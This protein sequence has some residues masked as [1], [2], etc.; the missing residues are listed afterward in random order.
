MS[1]SRSSPGDPSSTRPPPPARRCSGAGTGARG[2][3][4]VPLAVLATPSGCRG[5]SRRRSRRS[6]RGRR[7]GSGPASP[8]RSRP[9]SP[10]RSC[11]G[12]RIRS[13][14]RPLQGRR[15][16]EG[17]SVELAVRRERQRFEENIRRRDHRL[18]HSVLQPAPAGPTSSGTGSGSG[19]HVGGESLLSVGILD[20][21]DN[22]FAHARVSRQHG[23]DLGELH[24]EAPNLHL[25][26]APAQQLQHASLSPPRTVARRVHPRSRLTVRVGHEP[27][28]RLTRIGDIAPRHARARRCTARRPHPPEPA[29]AARPERTSAC[30]AT[31]GRSGPGRPRLRGLPAARRSR[32]CR[33]S[34][35]SGRRS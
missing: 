17:R 19:H 13:P 8:P 12:G 30:R 11:A 28:G 29:R 34:P 21:H 32:C 26:V 4:P 6:C 2:R 10:P 22:R 20:D 14:S 18:G 15:E 27:L 24:A 25:P 16:A 33:S 1:N 7:R 3:R 35:R 23:L 31:G 5:S 9:G